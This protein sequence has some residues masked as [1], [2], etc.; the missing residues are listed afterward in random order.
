MIVNRYQYGRTNVSELQDKRRSVLT[1]GEAAE[2]KAAPFEAASKTAISITSDMN[3]K[4]ERVR[5]L[6]NQTDRIAASTDAAVVATRLQAIRKQAD[7][8]KWTQDEF[9][10][11]TERELGTYKQSINNISEGNRDRYSVFYAGQETRLRAQSQ[12]EGVEI[13]TQRTKENWAVAFDAL[14]ATK[15]YEGQLKM[16]EIAGAEEGDIRL[17][18][19]VEL[20][21]MERMVEGQIHSDVLMDGYKV[22]AEAGIADEFLTSLEGQDLTDETIAAFG[23]KQSEY[24]ALTKSVQSK[25]NMERA[26]EISTFYNEG[27]TANTSNEQLRAK[28]RE[29]GATN[30]GMLNEWHNRRDRLRDDVATMNS[31]FLDPYDTKQRR[32]MNTSITGNT[33]QERFNSALGLTT[34]YRAAPEWLDGYFNSSSLNPDTFAQ[35][36]ENWIAYHNNADSIPL[37]VPEEVVDKYDLYRQYRKSTTDSIE[38]SS[39]V[40]A[41]YDGQ[42]SD[43]VDLYRAAW[44]DKNK[45][46]GGEAPSWHINKRVHDLLEEANSPKLA[47]EGL[48]YGYNAID[49]YPL[50]LQSIIN[51]VSRSTY[52]LNGGNEEATAQ[53]I[54]KHLTNGGWSVTDVNKGVTSGEVTFEA[55]WMKQAPTRSTARTRS[56]LATDIAKREADGRGFYVGGQLKSVPADEIEIWKYQAAPD[57][58][59][60]WRMRWNGEILYNEN[61]TPALFQYETYVP[62]DTETEDAAAII[63]QMQAED[64][65][66][67]AKQMTLQKSIRETII[68]RPRT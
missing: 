66:A 47:R 37:G 57:G 3:A 59:D 29:V 45:G 49:E 46:A 23:E 65:E 52:G 50:E 12:I 16:L 25:L 55:G 26:I 6:Q 64:E 24:D 22:A 7:L 4:A 1:A 2:A 31:E 48:I 10:S 5:T 60:A 40:L 54:V 32:S 63:N 33:V 14:G 19:E 28:F 8:E 61:Y 9:N 68:D 13:H 38:A 11:A 56:E 53:T 35:A 20:N 17:F 44:D 67:E 39:A 51:T 36:A 21:Q 30:Y 42:T 27:I 41:H 58:S 62:E 18:E 43:E 34:T 15:D